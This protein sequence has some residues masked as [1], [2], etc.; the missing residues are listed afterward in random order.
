MQMIFVADSSHH[1]DSYN[2]CAVNFLGAVDTS[3]VS[4]TN[5]N[6]IL[7]S[8]SPVFKQCCGLVCFTLWK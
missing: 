1:T 5:L 7:C 4:L 3:A 8:F 6:I 2:V